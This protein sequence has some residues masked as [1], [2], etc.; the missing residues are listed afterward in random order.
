MLVGEIDARSAG[1]AVLEEKLRA[2]RHDVEIIAR[3]ACTASRATPSLDGLP[4]RPG[5]RTTFSCA[6]EFSRADARAVE[7][8][9]G[10][11]LSPM[12]EEVAV[13]LFA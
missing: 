9:G 8:D 7:F 1:G 12:S 11:V 13:T 3:P 2:V 10:S 6:R 4:T 5:A